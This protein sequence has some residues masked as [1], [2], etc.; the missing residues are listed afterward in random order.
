MQLKCVWH[1]K[2]QYLCKTLQCMLPLVLISFIKKHHFSFHWSSADQR[3]TKIKAKNWQF[4]CKNDL[5]YRSIVWHLQF[6][7]QFA[8]S[9]NHAVEVPVI[10]SHA[11]VKSTIHIPGRPFFENLCSD[12]QLLIFQYWISLLHVKVFN[13]Q[14]TWWVVSGLQ[15]SSKLIRLDVCQNKFQV[16]DKG[17][18]IYT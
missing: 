16:S 3:D 14:S 17:K 9:P 13:T 7:S 4:W 15:P 5:T 11:T 10:K 18:C 2:I 8:V 6:F 12:W 1:Q